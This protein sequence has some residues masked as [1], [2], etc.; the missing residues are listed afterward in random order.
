MRGYPEKY[1][2]YALEKWHKKNIFFDWKKSYK[3]AYFVFFSTDIS[4][5]VTSKFLKHQ[6]KFA[7]A[8]ILLFYYFSLANDCDISCELSAKQTI[9]M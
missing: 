8:Y 4:L 3:M 6:V 1:F 9:Y 7:A 2:S 5:L